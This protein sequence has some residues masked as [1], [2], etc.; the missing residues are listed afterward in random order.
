MNHQGRISCAAVCSGD[1]GERHSGTAAR[2]WTLG[3]LA[4]VQFMVVANAVV[5][6]IA[7]P[8]IQDEL[9]ASGEAM[10]WVVNAYLIGAGGL[11]LLG[12]WLGDRL[13]RRLMFIAGSAVFALASL[14]AGLAQN[15]EWLVGSRFMQAPAWHWPSRRPGPRPRP[16]GVGRDRRAGLGRRLGGRRSAHRPAELAAGVRAQPSAGP[17]RH[18]IH[19][20]TGR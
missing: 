13:G 19:P 1:V 16:R 20:A 4:S 5:V 9:V 7:I 6:N 8:A 12:G 2:W 10:A 17:A 18:R 3:V 14:S 11:L 15:A